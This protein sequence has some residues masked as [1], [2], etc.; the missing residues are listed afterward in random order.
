MKAI[1]CFVLLGA[2]LYATSAVAAPSIEILAP[3][4]DATVPSGKVLVIGRVKGGD[5]RSVEIDV[6]GKVHHSA[7]TSSGGFMATVYLMKGK[8][9]LAVH[10]D[11]T[12]VDMSIIASET[13]QTRGQMQGSTAC[14]T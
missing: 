9:V 7:I 4:E 14:R 12:S 10:A 1:L 2:I 11:G 8:N 5:F 13:G 3:V 6:N